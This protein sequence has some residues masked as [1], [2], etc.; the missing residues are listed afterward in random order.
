MRQLIA[1]LVAITTLITGINL[2]TPPAH[3][4]PPQAPAQVTTPEPEDSTDR[5]DGNV[6]LASPNTDETCEVVGLAASAGT[7]APE[8]CPNADQV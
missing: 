6:V 8:G 3:A 1:G 4:A 7:V 5:P 2:S